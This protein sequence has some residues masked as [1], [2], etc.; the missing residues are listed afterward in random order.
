M[1]ASVQDLESLLPVQFLTDEMEVDQ[2]S[3]EDDFLFCLTQKL[4]QQLA[5]KNQQSTNWVRPGSPES[6]LSGNGSWSFSSNGSLNDSW[7]L[8]QNHMMQER[9]IKAQCS[10]SPSTWG[11][12]QVK[13]KTHQP[14]RQIQ[15]RSGGR[16]SSTVGYDNGICTRPLGLPPSAWPPLQL[17]N[18]PGLAGSQQPSSDNYGGVSVNRSGAKRECVGTGVF[19]PRRY[20]NDK[21]NH[22]KKSACSSVWIP[23][24]A[25]DTNCENLNMQP[26]PQRYFKTD[27]ASDY[28]SVMAKRNSH[29]TNQN[30]NLQIDH[31]ILQLP[32]E[33]IY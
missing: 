10:S 14:N 8:N 22:S 7:Q 5:T 4:T 3:Q 20:S 28:D 29:L 18:K 32:Q 13:P 17:N 1:S 12:K 26:N 27:Y 30:G 2:S 25:I 16:R 33:W 21:P 9:E 23:S 6:V 15:S 19:L 24:K 11:K 31:E